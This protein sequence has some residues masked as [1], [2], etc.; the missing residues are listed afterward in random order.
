MS[1]AKLF[2]GTMCAYIGL[3]PEQGPWECRVVTVPTGDEKKVGLPA[4]EYAFV[5]LYCVDVDC[6][7]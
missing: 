1:R 4:G 3:F 5:E 7:C 2:E 6:D